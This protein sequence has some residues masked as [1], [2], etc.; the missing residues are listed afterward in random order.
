V[1]NSAL[2]FP[3]YCAGGSEFKKGFLQVMTGEIKGQGNSIFVYFF[4]KIRISKD[5]HAK[6]SKNTISS[7]N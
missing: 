5:N 6:S 3:I 2:N 7:S 1:I 4:I